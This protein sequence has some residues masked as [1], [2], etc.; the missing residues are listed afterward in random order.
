MVL[1]LCMKLSQSISSRRCS[2][3]GGVGSC[4]H[5]CI[6]QHKQG[7]G[8]K[9]AKRRFGRVFTTKELYGVVQETWGSIVGIYASL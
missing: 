5:A 4:I 9:A 7:P 3:F 6:M 8:E 1:A 2:L